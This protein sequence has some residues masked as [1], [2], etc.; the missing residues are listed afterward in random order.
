VTDSAAALAGRRALVTGA[1]RGI[2]YAIAARLDAAGAEVIGLDLAEEE[3]RAAFALLSARSRFRRLDVTDEQEWDHVIA[4]MG[5]DAPHV[6]VNNAGG[7]LSSAIVHEHAVEAW[8]QTLDLNLTS[9]F[10]GMRA[11]IP[12]ML[13]RGEGSIVNVGSVS[14]VVGQADAPAYQAAKAGVHLLTRNAAITYAPMGIRVNSVSPSV[15]L[16]AAVAADD[17]AR[18]AAFVA[19]VPAGRAGRPEDVA[20]AVLYLVSDEAQYTIG[21][22]LP[23]DGGYLA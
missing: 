5:A 22:N 3:G 14:G 20:A 23:V 21:V 16:T 9:V 11:V 15:I 18:T 2:G 12:A 1:A 10:L 13:S 6:L 4:E 19:R 8:R 17:D 7:L